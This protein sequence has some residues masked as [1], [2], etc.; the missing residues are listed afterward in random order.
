[1]PTLWARLDG[2]NP[3]VHEGIPAF[4]QFYAD[5]TT[6]DHV[7]T[8]YSCFMQGLRV[9]QH[10]F[11]PYQQGIPTGDS[12]SLGLVPLSSL[13]RGY[14][15]SAFSNLALSSKS[16]NELID[17]RQVHSNRSRPTPAPDSKGPVK[18]PNP[19]AHPEP[20]SRSIQHPP[21]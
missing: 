17:P 11:D 19:P 4:I 3:R 12:K 20:A 9:R 16:D 13:Q 5:L 14:L 2:G 21:R 6:V 10:V 18:P 15:K 8:R 7:Q 1:M